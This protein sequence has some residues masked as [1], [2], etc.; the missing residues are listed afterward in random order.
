MSGAEEH[1][2]PSVL[3]T[4]V[5]TSASAKAGGSRGVRDGGKGRG[6]GRRGVGW[7]GEGTAWMLP[8]KGKGLE[9][10]DLT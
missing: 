6:E 7:W 2:Q 4:R 8:E 10:R 3:C 9:R 1:V 5:R